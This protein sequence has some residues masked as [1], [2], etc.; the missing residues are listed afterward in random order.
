MKTTIISGNFSA[1]IN[2]IGAELFSLKNTK[3]NLEYIWEGDAAFWPKHSPILFPIVGTLKN[4]SYQYNGLD[5]NLSRHGFARDMTFEVLS[6]TENSVTFTLQASSETLPIYPFHFEL[7]LQYT[8]E[9]SKLHFNYT[10]INREN[11]KLPF[12]LGAHPAIA[13]PGNF[14]SYSLV[15]EKEEVLNYNLLENNLIVDKTSTLVSKDKI[16]PLNYELFKNDAL[17]F[18]ELKSKSITMLKNN[19]P[20]IKVDYPAFPHL[21]IWTKVNAPFLCIEPWFGYSDTENSTG[22]LFEKEG[23][24]VLEPNALFHASFSIEIL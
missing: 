19:L 22:N 17:I 5:Y 3:T 23:I 11:S 16:V 15:F 24:Q 14:E 1:S 20:Y 10:V 9:N 7:Q 6:K 21:G 8:L 12:S 18:K 13:L 4:N 2:H